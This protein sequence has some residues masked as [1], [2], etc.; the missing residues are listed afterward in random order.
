MLLG[1]RPI[2]RLTKLEPRSPAMATVP[3]KAPTC[4]PRPISAAAPVVA[5]TDDYDAANGF[6]RPEQ[7]TPV[8]KECP[9]VERAGE[10]VAHQ[11]L[12]GHWR[13]IG[14]RE[15]DQKLKDQGCLH[16]ASSSDWVRWRVQHMNSC[17]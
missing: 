1:A 8:D 10:A 11:Q 15:Q 16:I 17:G 12:G 3:T 6:R 4:Q 13:A 7:R 14:H 2:L 9:A 5:S